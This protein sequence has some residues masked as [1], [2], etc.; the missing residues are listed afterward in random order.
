MEF[1]KEAIEVI[2]WNS[3]SR[4]N[5]PVSFRLFRKKGALTLN[6]SH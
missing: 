2:T 3:N 6:I 1:A 4:T 5:P